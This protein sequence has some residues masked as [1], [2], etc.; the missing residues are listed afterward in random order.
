MSDLQTPQPKH[1]GVDI[2]N[3]PRLNKNTGFSEEE[4]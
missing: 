1:S 2:L 3:D 4:R